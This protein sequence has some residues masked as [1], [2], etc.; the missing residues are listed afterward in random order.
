MLRRWIGE[1]GAV[2]GKT[3]ELPENIK[4]EDLEKLFAKMLAQ[5]AQTR[6]VVV[7]VDALNQ[8]LPHRAR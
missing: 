8:F 1:L 4:P 2:V 3:P 7:L 6:R 5:V